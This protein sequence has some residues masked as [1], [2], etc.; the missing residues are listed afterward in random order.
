V[1]EGEERKK[2]IEQSTNNNM[3]PSLMQVNQGGR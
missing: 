3:Q 2:T 1:S